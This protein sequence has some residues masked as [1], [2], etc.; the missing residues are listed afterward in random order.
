MSEELI[1]IQETHE[2]QDTPKVDIFDFIKCSEKLNRLINTNDL[3]N[4]NKHQHNKLIFVYSAPKVGST[5]I[6]SS[7]RIFGIEM[8]DII[9]IHDEEMLHVLANIKDITV[10]EI[11]L[12]NKYLGKD[13][14]VI[15]VYRSPIER[16]ISAFFEKID[17]YHFNADEREVNNYNVVKV[18][19]RFNNIFPWIGNGD[20]FIDKYNIN[21]PDSFDFINKYV[22]VNENGIKYI[23]LRLTDSNEWGNILTNIFGFNIRTIKDYESSNKPIKDLYNNFKLH[24]RIPV[25]LLDEIMNDKY[26]KYY[27][28]QEE[29]NNYYNGWL[30]KST[31]TIASYNYEQY[32]LY[33]TISIENCHIDKIQADHYFDE[34]CICKACCLK[35]LETIS[36]ILKGIEVKDRIVHTEAKS[37][38]IQKR[39]IRA[40]RINHII[41][42]IP[43]KPRGKDFKHDMKSIVSKDNRR[44]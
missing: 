16:K 31:D 10:N 32:K 9:H 17:S 11:I 8:I 30:V 42:Q 26:L 18:I 25:N 38:L 12:F 35:R 14:Y 36:K 15:N 29:I 44:F 37:E 43:P 7:F 13:V 22:L 3:L 39:V 21:I 20:H 28:S 19:N 4:I 2:Q 24:Y 41:Q 33:E 6:V 5:S 1:T 27:Y 34:G 23:T 40:N